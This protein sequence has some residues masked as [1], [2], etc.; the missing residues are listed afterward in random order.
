MTFQRMT[1][2]E[3]MQYLHCIIPPANSQWL[4]TEGT[5]HFVLRTSYNAHDIELSVIHHHA[6]NGVLLHTPYLTFV[7]HYTRLPYKPWEDFTYKQTARRPPNGR[8]R[9]T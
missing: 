2:S 5:K 4:D 1:H 8:A 9:R 7:E 6:T 3:Q